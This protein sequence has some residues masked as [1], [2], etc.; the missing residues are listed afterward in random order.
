MSAKDRDPPSAL[1]PEKLRRACS[2]DGFVD[3]GGEGE[4]VDGAFG[5]ARA[6][7]AISLANA[8]PS[9]GYN[10]FVMGGLGASNKRFV[11]DMLERAAQTAPPRRDWVYVNNFDDPQRPIAI[12]LSAG[13]AIAFRDSMQDLIDDLRASLPAVFE[14]EDYRNR[15]ETIDDEIQERQEAAFEELGARAREIGAT[16]VRTPM[17]FAVA[18]F[19]DDRIIPPE[20]FQKLSPAERE[21]AQKAISEIQDQ[22]QALMRDLPRYEKERRDAVRRL[23]RETAKLAVEQSIE[24]RRREFADMPE[25]LKYLEDARRTLIERAAMFLAA[26]EDAAYSSA[27]LLAD[28]SF[29]AFTVNVLVASRDGAPGAPV[30]FEDHPTLQNL[31]GRVEHVSRQGALITNF[32]L[33]KP[34]ALHRA[35]GGCLVLEARQLLAEPFAWSALKRA[36]RAKALRISPPAEYFGFATTV[37]LEPDPI[38][39][40]V[41]VAIFG[42]RLHYYLLLELDPEMRELFKVVAD[43]EDEADRTPEREGQLATVLTAIRQREDLPPIEREAAEALVDYAA[44]RAGDGAKLSLDL[45]PVFDRLTEAGHHARR[46]GSASISREDVAQSIA[47]EQRRIGRI[48]EKA[49]EAIL[50]DMALI[51]TAGAAIGQ[52]NGLS[53]SQIGDLQFGR[54]TRITARA[55]LGAG[56]VVDIERE[57]ELGGP[58]H[59]KGVL[60]LSGFLAARY[61]LDS[62]MSL[63]ATLVFEQSYG[64]VEGDSASCAELLA[65]LSAL[66]GAPLRQDIAITGSVN[67]RGQVQAIGGVNDKIE[68]FFDICEKRGLTGTQGVVIPASNVQQLMLREDVAEA[69]ADGRFAVYAMETIDEGLSLMTGL[70][71]GERG[72]DGRFPPDSVNGRVEAALE[73][74][75]QARRAFGSRDDEKNAS[76]STPS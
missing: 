74:F 9:S 44:R 20:E 2:L 40:D 49:Q 12:G 48:R 1:V 50:R 47:A 75:A 72:E 65:L 18:P 54:P 4:A 30:V 13:R 56:K 66:S 6:V 57:V 58:I 46:A 8:I 14:S 5:Q 43:F 17:G 69:C 32:T 27:E 51:E 53:V 41:K 28:G 70:S 68:G 31:I 62:P 36:L 19:R 71:A 42:E 33:I 29:E 59:S 76:G 7:E 63:S 61:A 34:G 3:R 45:E 25:V 55:R 52:I 35:N 37:S 24:A 67:Q 16:I 39:L 10:L 60:I 23:D 21:A 26:P 22:L 73:R 15:R 11:L 38:P 64:G